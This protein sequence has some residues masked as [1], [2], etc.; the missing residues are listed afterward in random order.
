MTFNAWL[1]H[2]WLSGLCDTTK[3]QEKDPQGKV[4]RDHLVRS[5]LLKAGCSGSDTPKITV[6]AITSATTPGITG[7]PTGTRETQALHTGRGMSSFLLASEPG[8][9]TVLAPHPLL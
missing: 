7:T 9:D 4:G 2:Q 3:S 1:C 5:G 8:A 6:E